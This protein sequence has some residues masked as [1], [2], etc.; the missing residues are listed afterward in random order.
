LSEED[1]LSRWLCVWNPRKYLGERTRQELLADEICGWPEEDDLE[2]P[3]TDEGKPGFESPYSSDRE[4]L[5]RIDERF[6]ESKGV[7]PS[8]AR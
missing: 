8:P 1:S 5:T 6:P 7:P 2:P 4:V 3:S